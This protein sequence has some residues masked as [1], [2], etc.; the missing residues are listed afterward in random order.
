MGL[1]NVLTACL[2]Q[3]AS[4]HALPPDLI[5]AVIM[6]EGG[7]QGIASPNLNNTSDLGIMQ[8]N[9]GAWLGLVAKAHFSGDLHAAYMR[10]RDDGCYN[11]QVGSWIL[12]QAINHSRG[13]VWSGVARYH[14]A[15]PIYNQRYQ[16]QV[17]RAWLSLRGEKK[18]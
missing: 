11:I 14:S 17:K 15:T 7:H 9:T 6:V 13:D 16:C 8:I 18:D 4:V 12:R 10:L 1:G 2:L 3:A 5:A